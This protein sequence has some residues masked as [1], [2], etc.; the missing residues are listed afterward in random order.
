MEIRSVD[1]KKEFFN[2]Y[3]IVDE[4]LLQPEVKDRK[5]VVLSIIGEHRKGKSF[6]LD[7]CLRYMYANVSEK[8]KIATFLW[9]LQDGLLN[10]FIH[11]KT[12]FYFTII[13]L[14]YLSI[15]SLRFWAQLTYVKTLKHPLK[16]LI[17]I[18]VEPSQASPF[19]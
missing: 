13:I 16:Y 14:N 4:I 7:F 3:S 9:K 18:T 12:N 10:K 6:F 11:V 15:Y 19:I 2:N 17:L 1:G 8:F 5:V